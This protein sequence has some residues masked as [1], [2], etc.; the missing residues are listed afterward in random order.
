MILAKKDSIEYS[1]EVIIP[2][3]DYVNKFIL[4]LY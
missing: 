2:A 1:D 3:G 4:K